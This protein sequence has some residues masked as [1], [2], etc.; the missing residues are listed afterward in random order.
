MNKNTLN[1]FLNLNIRVKSHEVL[2]IAVKTEQH[3]S[4]VRSDNDLLHTL[5]SK[6]LSQLRLITSEKTG[7]DVCSVSVLFAS[8]KLFGYDII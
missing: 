3:G 4:W 8:S 6:T 1:Y 5:W 7:E 2:I